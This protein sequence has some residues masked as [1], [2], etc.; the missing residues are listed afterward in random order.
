MV[1]TKIKP[2]VMLLSAI[3][4]TGCATIE[5]QPSFDSVRETITERIGQKVYWKTGGAEDN[6]IAE[7]VRGLLQTPLT[8]NDAVQIALL[9]NPRLQAIYEE[10]GV[11]Q[12]ALVQAGLVRNPVLE[13]TVRFQRGDGKNDLDFDITQDF[14]SVL[15]LSMRKKIAEAEYQ[16]TRLRVSGEV[17]DLAA[18]VRGIFYGAQAD[19]QAIEMLQQ[20]IIATDAA[21]DAARK[22]HAAGNIN[23]LALDRQRAMHEESLLLLADA[24]AA[25]VTDRER[26]NALMGLW[27][28]ATQ[29][30]LL[31]R[32]PDTSV[33]LFDL[34]DVER[35]AVERSLDL[36]IARYHIEEIGRQ[37]G[38]TKATS[39]VPELDAGF[40]WERDE[41]SWSQGPSIGLQIPIFDTGRARRAGLSAKLNQARRDYVALAIEIRASV[42]A[43]AV[44][45]RK[46][47]ARAD[48]LKNVVLPLRQRIV[49]GAQLEY[50][51]MQIGV[52]QLLQEQRRQ[53]NTGQEYINT[54]RDYWQERAM[55]DQLLAGRMVAMDQMGTVTPGS[56]GASADAGGH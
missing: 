9:T 5:P 36:A 49:A 55:L 2:L 23:A 53:I 13:A 1:N 22:L 3:L 14:L 35:R 39:L 24:E 21:L 52:F 34:A 16:A 56:M 17:L 43:A 51:A 18:Q 33:A 40:S 25:L 28:T 8:A 50:N 48:H 47:R 12:A 38:L 26:L 46:A 30:T 42:R 45:L 11:A 10:L 6:T 41:G 20:V 19:A 7:E 44:G 29:W 27:G 15:T 4:A 37:L 54:L 32:L 31:R